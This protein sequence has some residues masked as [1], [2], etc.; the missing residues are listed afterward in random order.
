[1]TDGPGVVPRDF[2]DA[3]EVATVFWRGARDDFPPAARF[4]ADDTAETSSVAVA[5]E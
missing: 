2:I 3:P 1:V 5:S 4:S